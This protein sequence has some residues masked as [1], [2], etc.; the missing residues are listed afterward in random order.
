M[1]WVIKD[2]GTNEY[3]RRSPGNGWYHSDLSTARFYE[4]RVAAERTI[5]S[6]NHHVSYPGTRSLVAVEVEIRELQ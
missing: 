6:G 1:T 3:Y 5:D 2:V 4:S